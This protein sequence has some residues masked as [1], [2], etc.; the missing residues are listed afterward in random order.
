MSGQ[1]GLEQVTNFAAPVSYFIPT[2]SEVG[3][4]QKEAAELHAV[5]DNRAT[6]W[7]DR[8]RAEQRLRSIERRIQSY[9]GEEKQAQ[10]LATASLVATA[11]AQ[12]VRVEATLSRVDAPTGKG[13]PTADGKLRAANAAADGKLRAHN[14]AMDPDRPWYFPWSSA[15]VLRQWRADKAAAAA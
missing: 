8:T 12:L 11:Q 3:K 15:E 7:A 6:A 9:R 5:V 13:S 10:Q 14:A 2:A 1:F 4:L